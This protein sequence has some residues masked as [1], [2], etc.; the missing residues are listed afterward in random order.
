MSAVTDRNLLFGIFALH[1]SFMRRDAL[2]R[3][4]SAWVANKDALLSQRHGTLAGRRAYGGLARASS[5]PSPLLGEAPP[6]GGDGGRRDDDCRVGRVGRHRY[7][8]GDG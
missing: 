6:Y 7:T 8:P 1:N 5:P 4:I 3:A 2:I